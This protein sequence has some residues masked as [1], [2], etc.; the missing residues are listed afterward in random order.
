[1]LVEVVHLE[2]TRYM[3]TH[4]ESIAYN[5]SKCC[6]LTVHMHITISDIHPQTEKASRSTWLFSVLLFFSPPLEYFDVWICVYIFPACNCNNHSRQC[7]FNKEVYLLSGRKSGGIC[8]QCKHNTVGRYCSYCKET[9]Y[10]D[11]HLPITHPEICK[12]NDNELSN[13]LHSNHKKTR[14]AWLNYSSLLETFFFPSACVCPPHLTNIACISYYVNLVVCF[15][16]ISIDRSM[17]SSLVL[18]M[19][20]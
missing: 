13:R 10:R 15:V 7:R 1:M 4:T 16:L 11:P 3:H 17:Y 8:I 18:S 19:E 14:P 2:Q 6:L 9:F 20:W 12:G 5:Y